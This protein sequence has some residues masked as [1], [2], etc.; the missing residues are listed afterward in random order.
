MIAW[1]NT[2]RWKN[3]LIIWISIF[4]IVLPHF[5][6]RTPAP[7]YEFIRWAVICSTIAAIGNIIN[8]WLDV[9]QD[10]ENKKPNIFI[11]NQ[12]KKTG[13]I[14]IIILLIL[15]IGAIWYCNN[16]MILSLLAVIALCMLT[17]YNFIFKKIAIIGNIIIGILS[18][19]VFVGIDIIV[20]SRLIYFEFGF[21]NKQIE[22]FAG[23]AF[24]T[25]V[26]REIIKDAEDRKGD[27]YAGFNTIA[28]FLNDQAIAILIFVISIG[29]SLLVYLF[30]Q[31]RQTHFINLYLIYAA[32]AN[33]MSLTATILL[34]IPHPG[35]YI[36]ASRVIK[37][38]M[39]GSLIIYLLLSY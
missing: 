16:Q 35:K 8:D 32:W 4:V 2:I 13:T 24:V 33:A 21:N 1:L 12:Q 27:L 28:R 7:F 38:G 11:N 19:M 29:G 20:S 31:S 14:L 6:Y 18:A 17:L 37:A 36:R 39:L 34:L 26:I 15:C 3:L 25:T 22:L 10:K 5:D 30:M 9:K 23:F